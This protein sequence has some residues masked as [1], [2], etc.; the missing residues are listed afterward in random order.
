MQLTTLN[1]YAA[2]LHALSSV[3][4]TSAF[5]ANGQEANFDTN[6]YTYKISALSNDDKTATLEYYRYLTVTT[7]AIESMIA[8]IFLITSFFHTFYAT[9]GFGTGVYLKEIKKGYNRFRWLEYAI[10]STIMI[11]VL[12]VIS[13]VRDFDTVYEL[14]VLNAVLMSL[15]FF[16]EQTDNKQVQIAALSIGFLLVAAIFFTLL[17]NFYYRVDEVEKLGRKLP[18]WLDYVLLPMLFWWLSFGIVATMN[19][20]AKNKINYDYA[21]YEKFYI[22][23]SFL[24]KA[25]MGYYLTFGV[26]RDQTDKN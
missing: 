4:V 17:R 6:L 14:C 25:N 1:G 22:Y 24:S 7:S 16:L 15:G 10:T 5:Y 9:D 11:F 2:A 26:T 21:R 18:G 12:A 23:L 20:L 13:G 3:G 8:A 19:V